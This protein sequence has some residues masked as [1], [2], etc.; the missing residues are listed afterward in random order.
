MT[1]PVFF[2]A[3]ATHADWRQALASC[4]QQVVRQ[5]VLSESGTA[6]ASA[7]PTPPFTLG[8]CYL[9]DRHGEAA[10]AICEA[11]SREWPGVE[12]VGTVGVGV[13]ADGVEHFDEP[14]LSLLLCTLPAD[15]FRVFSG[16]RPLHDG[17]GFHPHTAL[18]HADG[19][20]PD[21][22]ELLDELSQRVAT[23][24]LFGG[25]ASSRSRTLHIAGEVLEGGLSGVAFNER[26]QL[27]SRVTQ[28]CQPIG[29]AR[30]ITACDRNLVTSLDGHPP[31]H[32]LLQDLGLPADEPLPRLAMRLGQT[33]AGLSEPGEDTLARPGQFGTDVRVRHL[34]GLEPNRGYLSVAEQ[35]HPG[36]LLTFC[37]RHADAARRDLVRIATELRELA[38]GDPESGQPPRRMAGALYVS[39]AGR[40][41]PHFGAAHAELQALRHALGEV[42]LVGF[43]AGGE[44]A[45]NHLYGY[46]GVLTVFTAPA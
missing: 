42:P 13:A 2:S 1:A 23:G 38:E 33:L 22:G 27:M 9:A 11:L 29:P 17:A 26:V 18:V 35:V 20:T 15:D 37:V 4:V 46:T 41:G 12:W 45:R 16:R 5:R 36:M 40:G 34:V 25:V 6:P 3:H 28:G 7:H 14:A 8:F 24:Y 39:C 30:R 43:F 31:L 44:I 32:W 10:S 19:R 21:L